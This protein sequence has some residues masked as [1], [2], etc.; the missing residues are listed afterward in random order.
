MDPKRKEE[1]K[2]KKKQ[3]KIRNRRLCSRCSPIMLSENI[4]F[5]A[6]IFTYYASPLTHYARI[7][8]D[9]KLKKQMLYQLRSTQKIKK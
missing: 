8:L 4:L 9:L 2:K 6:K 7:M 3:K 5:Y 1:M